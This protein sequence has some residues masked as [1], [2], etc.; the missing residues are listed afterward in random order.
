MDVFMGFINQLIT[1]GP[2]PVWKSAFLYRT[3]GCDLRILHIS[4][5]TPLPA[6]ALLQQRRLGAVGGSWFRGIARN[7]GFSGWTRGDFT[8]KNG[9]VSPAN[10]VYPL[11]I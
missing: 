1:G 7:H 4:I 10:M 2:H 5:G 8:M 9:G 6:G 3:S 11:V